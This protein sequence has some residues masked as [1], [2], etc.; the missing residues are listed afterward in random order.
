MSFSIGIVGLPNVGKST[1]FNALTR[2]KVDASNYPFCTIDP[3][4]GIVEVPDERLQKLTEISRSVKTVPTVIEFVDIAG[5]VKGAHKG[6]GLGNQ[7]LSH[8][9]ETDAICEVLRAFEDPNI[10]HVEGRVNPKE[11]AETIKLE[12]IFADM[13]TVDKRLE[14][15][16]KEVRGSV[17]KELIKLKELCEKIKPGLE[18]GKMAGEIITDEEDKKVIKQLNLLTTKSFIYALNV[19]EDDLKKTKEE[20]IKKF[21]LDFDPKSVILVS[22]RIESELI[23]LSDAEAKEYLN[24]IGI[25]KSGLDKLI[26]ASY[27]VLNLITFLT[28]GEKESRAWTIQ[29]GF[30]APQAAGVIH[31]DFERG[32]IKAEVAS[33]KDF[34]ECNGWSGVKEKGLMRLEGK[35]YIMQDGDVCVF[36]FNV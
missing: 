32:F 36:K 28:S 9:R 20:I 15:L 22:A 8:I 3:N 33:Y 4:V 7:F 18:A 1:L 30:K 26:V 23:D 29:K 25:T 6:E 12:L 11:D 10:I 31:T 16:V 2:K 24:E 19:S 27:D 13:Q 5:L 21:S 14:K 17:D 35:E 34:V